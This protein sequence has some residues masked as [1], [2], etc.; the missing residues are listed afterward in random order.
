MTSINKELLAERGLEVP[1]EEITTMDDGTITLCPYNDCGWCCDFQQADGNYIVAFPGELENAE[2][3]TDHL[4]VID[5]D[6]HG[7]KKVICKAEHPENCDGGYKPLDCASYPLFPTQIDSEDPQESSFI[8]ADQDRC[9]IPAPFLS[10]HAR[11]TIRWWKGIDMTL[12]ELND[13]LAKIE[14][15]GY[16]DYDGEI[17]PDEA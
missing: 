13:F 17:D 5:D 6:Y 3:H 1:E 15:V 16:I 12:D 8:M 9:P 2:E 4:E 10:D 11:K 7:G 14:M